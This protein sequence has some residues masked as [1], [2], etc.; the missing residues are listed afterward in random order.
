LLLGINVSISL[1]G[2]PD[3]K[4]RFNNYPYTIQSVLK[5]EKKATFTAKTDVEPYLL[6]VYEEALSFKNNT[7]AGAILDTFAQIPFFC[8][9]E[10]FLNTKFQRDL[11]R[12]SYSQD[13]K[14]PPY[15]G[16]YGSTP[17]LWL[18]KYFIIK[19]VINTYQ[20]REVKKRGRK[21]KT[22]N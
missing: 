16:D 1:F 11:Q 3:N 9:I 6:K 10:M 14:T 2:I 8:N 15:Q 21:T 17:K 5:D 4:P 18:Q 12:Y 7:E 20:N 13:T 22:N 19:G